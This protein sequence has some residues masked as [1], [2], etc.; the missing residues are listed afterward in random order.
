MSIAE[1]MLNEELHRSG[2]IADSESALAEL[3]RDY[4]V[5]RDI[6]QDLLRRRENARVSMELDREK[7][8]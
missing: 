8:A 3:T 4:E 1:S 7:R 2:R 5:N 6:Y